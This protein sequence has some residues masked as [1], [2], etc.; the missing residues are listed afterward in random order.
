ML[1]RECIWNILLF[2]SGLINWSPIKFKYIWSYLQII[3]FKKSKIDESSIQ[4][5]I[6]IFMKN[7]TVLIF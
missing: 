3:K 6:V 7:V 2:F 4:V 5:A 1:K